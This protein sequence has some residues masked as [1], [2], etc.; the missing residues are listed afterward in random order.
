MAEYINKKL[1]S[2]MAPKR[3][4]NSHKLTFGKV[5]NIAGSANY[6][7]A[8]FLSSVS[9]LR[10]GAG[11]VTLASVKDVINSVSHLTPD[12]VYLTLNENKNGNISD[13]N[14]IKDLSSYN[15]ISIGCGISTD[16]SVKSFLI[17]LLS[18]ISLKQMLVIDADGI[19]LISSLKCTI[20]SK[21]T[22]IT[23][24]PKELSRLLNVSTEEINLNREKYAR[25]TSQTY[26]CITVLKGN[27][28]IV[29]NGEKI[30]INKTGNSALAKAGTGDVLTGT[31][32]GLLAQGT[33]VFNAAILGVYLHGLAG[34]IASSYLT[35]YG[36]LASDVINYL[37]Q[38]FAKVLSS[39]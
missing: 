26:D 21:N 32:A 35:Q 18:Q 14:V 19:N 5:L 25:I 20:P 9:A 39:E 7:G 10:S 16:D 38:A 15:V 13:D 30:Y 11:Y 8:A 28:T 33:N 24:H 2:D 27:G 37:P 31:I 23:P 17:G 12:L 36:V 6:K 3:I 4:Q 1:V 34:D 22:I 29:T